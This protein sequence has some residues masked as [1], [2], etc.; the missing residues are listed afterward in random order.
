MQVDRLRA[1]TNASQLWLV[2]A[3]TTVCLQGAREFL[4]LGTPAEPSQPEMGQ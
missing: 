4:D 3:T 2:I 1:L